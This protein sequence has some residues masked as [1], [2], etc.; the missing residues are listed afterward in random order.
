MNCTIEE[1][2]IK[3]ITLHDV[4]IFLEEDPVIIYDNKRY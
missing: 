3:K 4:K 1:I 2:S